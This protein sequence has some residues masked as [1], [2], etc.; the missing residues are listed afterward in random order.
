MTFLSA[1][2]KS[3]VKTAVLGLSVLAG[4]HASAM[5][6]YAGDPFKELDIIRP[7]TRVEAPDFTLEKLGGGSGSLADY[8]GKVV[9]L[10]FWATWCVPCRHEMPEL[11]K[12]WL[13]YRQ[14]GLIILGVSANRGNQRLVRDYVRKT[15]VTFPILLDPK[16]TVRNMYEVTG[17]PFTYIIGKDGKFIGKKVGDT[18]WKSPAFQRLIEELIKD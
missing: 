15:G 2:M 17:F 16:G 10:H 9:L 5:P 1:G 8:R 3:R 18:D 4:L 7:K 12:A 11:E 6:A 13:K 14:K